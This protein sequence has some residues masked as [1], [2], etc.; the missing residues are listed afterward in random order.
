MSRCTAPVLHVEIVVVMAEVTVMI[1]IPRTV[2]V[3]GALDAVE[4]DLAA[5]QNHAGRNQ[6][7]PFFTRQLKYNH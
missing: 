1:V 3:V 5:V 7:H 2:A 6:V 4:A